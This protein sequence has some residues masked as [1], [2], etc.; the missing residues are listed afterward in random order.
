MGRHG[1]ANV[2]FITG[3][4]LE[5]FEIHTGGDAGVNACASSRPATPAARRVANFIQPAG[6]TSS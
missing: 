1:T 5:H 3:K 2:Q 4:G 6:T